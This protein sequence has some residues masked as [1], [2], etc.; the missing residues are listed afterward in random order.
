[1]AVKRGDSGTDLDSERSDRCDHIKPTIDPIAG[2]LRVVV[3]YRLLRFDN[4]SL[5]YLTHE[6]LDAQLYNMTQ[7][8]V[9]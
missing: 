1:M 2:V 5:S 6:R 9:M 4:C 3:P 8:A 7:T